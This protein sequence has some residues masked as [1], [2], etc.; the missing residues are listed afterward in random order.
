MKRDQDHAQRK[1]V[2]LDKGLFLVHYKSAEDEDDPPK[3]LVSPAAGHERKVELVLHPDAD[4]ATLWQPGSHLVVRTTALA[5]LAVQV[6]PV[7]PN[8]SSAASVKVEP[9]S[10]GVPARRSQRKS[11]HTETG[12]IQFLA[13]VAGRGDVV[14]GPNEW[15]AGPTNP[16]RI[17]GLA[18]EWDDAPDDLIV[19]Y[20]VKTANQAGTPKMQPL[21][22]FVGTRGRALPLTGLVLEISGDEA[23]N[24]QI[25][26][27]ALF[28]SAPI[29]RGV[30]QRIVLSGPTGKEPLVGLKLSIE[31]IDQSD[32]FEPEKPVVTS[33]NKPK[34]TSTGRVR[35]FRSRP[36]Q[37][38]SAD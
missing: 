35:V 37:D 7:H 11:E 12:R 32:D 29:L 15:I 17:E 9:L 2:E 34:P 3:V 8:G 25:V 27:E 38:A 16:S 30:G 26:S 22:S 33:R 28:L 18:V 13:H 14:A 31:S 21:G 4:E 36:K 5:K 19:K 23:A 10:Q 6:V 24:Y 20:A 1:V